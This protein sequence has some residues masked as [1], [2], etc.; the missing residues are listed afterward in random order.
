MAKLQS[1]KASRTVE[2]MFARH[3]VF[4][5]QASN[6]RAHVQ[7][8]LVSGVGY[9]FEQTTKACNLLEG[10]CA[11]MAWQQIKEQDQADAYRTQICKLAGKTLTQYSRG[12]QTKSPSFK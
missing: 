10:S 3:A 4:V 1:C 9:A 7:G 11:A 5:S 8:V 12:K 6:H 2:Y